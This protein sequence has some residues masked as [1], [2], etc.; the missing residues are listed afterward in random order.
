MN[1]IQI[2]GSREIVGS[3]NDITGLT[4]NRRTTTQLEGDQVSISG[5]ASDEALET[6][7]ARGASVT[8]ISSSAEWNQKMEDI[9][10]DVE[11]NDSGNV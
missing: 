2:Q 11:S 3:L 5:Y 10:R 7:R 6:I 9:Y 4:L 8:V 1:I